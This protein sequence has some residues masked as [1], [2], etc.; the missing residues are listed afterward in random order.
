M[1]S[2][3]V[4]F[5]IILATVSASAAANT[6][7]LGKVPRG[8]I[9]D[10]YFIDS[11]SPVKTPDGPTFNLIEVYTPT[12]PGT[13]RTRTTYN[14]Q[15]DCAGHFRSALITDFR[16][17]RIIAT[18]AG[19]GINWT[20]FAPDS[21]LA[22]ATKWLADRGYCDGVRA[23]QNVVDSSQPTSAPPDRSHGDLGSVPLLPTGKPK[24]T[25]VSLAIAYGQLGVEIDASR[26][27]YRE[28]AIS[29]A[30]AAC[31]KTNTTGGQCKTITTFWSGC[32]YADSTT[33][34]GWVSSSSLEGMYRKCS[35]LGVTCN[36]KYVK[37]CNATI[38]W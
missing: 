1:R 36:E 30:L 16:G 23:Q 5:A 27:V 2:Y 32:V 12:E 38:S 22:E 20:T 28:N 24:Y 14:E 9:T 13:G 35:K 29:N 6:I 19:T 17:E 8:A 11:N 4:F 10:D 25:T 31:R 37:Q 18:R 26:D 21:A 33:P 34:T 15:V 7:Y 3:Q